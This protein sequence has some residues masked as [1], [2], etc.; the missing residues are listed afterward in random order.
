MKTPGHIVLSRKG[1]DSIYGGC[2]SPILADGSL[3]SMPIP[4]EAMPLKYRHINAVPGNC[5]LGDL[6]KVLTGC[7]V[8]ADSGVHLDPDVRPDLHRLCNTPWRPMFG[9]SDSAERH[10][11]KQKVC[12]DDLF[13]FFGW[14]RRVDHNFKFEKSADDEHVI[15]GWLQVEDYFDP[16]EVEPEWAKCHPHCLEKRRN[17]NRVYVGRQSLSFAPSKPGAGAFAVYDSKLRLT[18]PEEKRRRSEWLIPCFFERKLT[19]HGNA[20]WKREG[21]RCRISS[22]KIGQEFVFD[23]DGQEAQAQ[24]WLDKLFSGIPDGKSF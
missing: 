22:A 19:H 10:L 12:K 5:T 16:N 8:D 7:N 3:L 20:E 15:W 2:A 18:H 9:Q 6:V 13:L 21:S 14:F 17:Y 4:E 23:T 11:E 24:R 1:F